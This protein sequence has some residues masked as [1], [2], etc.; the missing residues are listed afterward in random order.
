[1]P[2]TMLLDSLQTVR[3]R[4]RWLG[5]VYGI[6]V[7]LASAVGLLLTIVLAD[8]TLNLPG[9]PRIVAMLLG[10]GAIIY[11]L[12]RWVL[13]PMAARLTLSDVAGRLEQAFPEFDDR[14]R[15]TVDFMNS[16]IPG[17]EAMK[18]RV[19]GE[20]AALAGKLDLSRAV[21][22]KPAWYA[23]GTGVGSILVAL[24]LALIMRDYASVAMSRLLSP[25]ARNDWPKRVQIAE[26]G[27]LPTRVPVGDRVDVKMKLT[28]GD[29][30]KAIIFYQYDN[31]PAIQREL[32]TRGEDGTY[33]ASIDARVDSGQ[34]NASLKIWM[35]A[36][37]D[38]KH[39]AP[40]TIVPRLSI[41]SVEA[42]LV[43]PAYVTDAKATTVDLI[44]APA[45]VADGSRVKL[46]V[47]FNK[48]LAANNPVAL[49]A[50]S[51]ELTIPQIDWKADT[52]TSASGTWMARKTMR[53]HVRATDSDG[54][55]NNALEEFE[56][57]VRPDQA[58]T[59][60]IENPRH[61]EERMA[62]SNIPLLGL[63]ED[64]YGISWLKLIVE[65]V[66][67]HKKWEIPL[68]DKGTAQTGVSVS[69][70][71]GALDRQRLRAAYSW[72]LSQL[73]DAKIQTGDVLEYYLLVKDNFDLDGQ[74]HPEVASGRLRITVISPDELISKVIDDLRQ[75]KNQ[76]Q[77]V[78]NAQERTRQQTNEL[79]DDLRKRP[80][81]DAADQAALQRLSN[82]QATAAA[83]TRQIAGRI[84]ELMQRMTENGANS[85]ELQDLARDVANDLQQAAENPMREATRQLAAAGQQQ[86]R[87]PTAAQ[88][89]NNDPNGTS[90]RDATTR[91]A[92]EQQ[93]ANGGATSRPS[94]LASNQ[95]N[96]RNGANPARNGNQ[97][98]RNG[99]QRRGPQDQ[100]NPSDQQASASA[101]QN[102]DQ[103]Q[104]Q[105]DT[106]QQPGDA[107]RVQQPA[108]ARGAQA[109][110]QS[111]GQQQANN[112]QRNG[113][114]QQANA[115]S[116]DQQQNAAN[117]EPGD[118]QNP[119]N[120][121]QQAD[122]GQRNGADQQA[123]AQSRGQQNGSNQQNPSGGPQQQANSQQQQRGSGGQQQ[124]GSQQNS[125][126][127]RG[128]GSQQNQ[129]ANG[130]Q[131][132]RNGGNQSPSG[133]QQAQS[134][135]PQQGSSQ[136]QQ[137]QRQEAL[138]QANQNQQQANEQLDRA[139]DRMASIGSVQQQVQRLRDILNQQQQISQQTRQIGRDNVGRTP[140]Q[141]S[142]QDRDKLN[143]VADQQQQLSEQTAKALDEMQ[144]MS[145]QM[146]RSDPASAQAMQR[147]AQRGQQQ[148]TSQN[149]QR[150]A[151]QARQNQ[152]GG[153]Q[154]AQRQAE[155]GL[156]MVLNDLNEAEKHR[157]SEL[158]R[159][160][161]DLQNQI[162][163]LIRRQATHNLDTVALQGA[164]AV[165]KLDVNVLA[166]LM[167]KAERR[168]DDPPA[169]VQLPQLTALQE[170]TERN[171]RDLGKTAEET[172]SG[173][174]AATHLTRAAGRM[175]RALVQ[176]HT[177]K[178]A[179]AYDP[180]Q[181]E[182]LTELEGAQRTVSE[183]QSQVDQQ[184]QEQQREG[185]RQRYVKIRDAQVKLNEEVTK[186]DGAR[187]PDGGLNRPEAVR[188]GQLPAE[189]N[190][191]S[192][193]V[194]G[195]AEDLAAA[196]SVVYVW[197]NKDIV[198]SMNDVKAD[199]S[200]QTTGVSTRAEQTR[201]VD[202]LNAMIR[203]LQ[204]RPRDSKFAQNDNGQQQQ[205]DQQGGQGQAGQQ[206]RPPRLP[207]EAE[208][209]L[210]QDLQRAVNTST[211]TINDQPNKDQ[212]KLVALGG[213]QGEL[214]GLLDQLLQN[215]SRGQLKLGPEPDV[216]TQLPEEAN[217][218]QVENQELD[219]SL[220]NGQPDQ[221]R[222][223]KQANLIGD[224]MA[225]SRQRLADKSDPGKI[226]QLIQDRIILDFD[227]L[228]QQAQQQQAETRNQQQRRQQQQQQRQ[229][230]AN[231][232]QQGQQQQ[233]AQRN[234]GQPEN[235]SDRNQDT[236]SQDGAAASRL[237]GQRQVST[238]M[239]KEIRESAAEWGQ[240]SPRL[241][242]A[243]L[244][245]A[246]EKIM[247][248]YSKIVQ[249][250][251]KSVANQ[252]AGQ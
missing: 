122:N 94:D 24:L 7:L 78:R 93:D 216:K 118:Q 179:E 115:Q 133:Q 83:Q 209:R 45:L 23:L 88:P 10:V 25:F 13:Q 70:A 183:Q 151:Q 65:R 186:I 64:D 34:G 15:S 174:E 26:A 166:D 3:R 55:T 79:A 86:Q 66:G 106:N 242:D 248:E 85:Q 108:N 154:S 125:P 153:A 30:S 165:Q 11:L 52:S 57:V 239:S 43:P 227:S 217:G 76:I 63:A 197:S 189:Q 224:R 249:D 140:E 105:R 191:L 77:G 42:E 158:Q 155:M 181:I 130:Q 178:L 97:Q 240:V 47:Q 144:K 135:Q 62:Q 44:S 201:I 143:Q 136:E 81:L 1:M 67:D 9:F 102:G 145:Q 230:Q 6:G 142:Q 150:A 58:P 219:Q 50:A 167:A 2:P 119:T 75:L 40:I 193:Q 129:Q 112:G 4:V 228:I 127:Q 37:D 98:A 205:Q 176:L 19:V 139:L 247:E 68:L 104:Q 202:Q 110:A 173:A 213:R 126:S 238:D 251:Y 99:S 170:Q 206:K 146:N 131:Q 60:Q 185:L 241:R 72:E 218:E 210:L 17:S 237:P 84:N 232:R 211:K 243:V 196:T 226:T 225:R 35:T 199:L 120:G 101:A 208:L 215:S 107:A 147:A 109:N 114:D 138:A 28:R 184:L 95:Q 137:Q 21:V 212:P 116:S 236:R 14:L 87:T 29:Y 18:Q 124:P 53:F 172:P 51:E 233:Q 187:T 121:Q 54:F 71:E 194:N 235:Q 113:A 171:T 128:Q 132:Q 20:A 223:E 134:G 27:N 91:P 159:Q 252:G 96:G 149:Q 31:N 73:A 180:N 123:N 207:A 164:D 8:Y 220:L 100:Q 203:N 90:A 148:Q 161:E 182:A 214:R 221:D 192:E 5:L 250:Y 200:K 204:V 48:Q 168:P 56:I 12:Y 169:N 16:D 32:M 246:D 222:D 195:I 82:Q 61:N 198:Q 46:N 163:N 36:G 160:L 190:T 141:M 234:Q 38:E 74:T 162:G 157:L 39:L 231:Q 175:E 188:L 152:Q 22:A 244:D 69:R 89:N 92:G 59:V 49:V 41:K 229:Q 156:E 117:R 80:Q 103:Q 177:N 245:G 111:R 33:T